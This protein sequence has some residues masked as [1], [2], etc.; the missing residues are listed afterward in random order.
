[1]ITFFDTPHRAFAPLNVWRELDRVMRDFDR[2]QPPSRR[3]FSQAPSLTEHQDRYELVMAAP[4]VTPKDVEIQ[5]HE[6]VLSLRAEAKPAPQEGY[7]AT[8]RERGRYD[9][10]HSYRLPSQ[11]DASS[12]QASLVDGVLTIRVAKVPKPEPKLIPVSGA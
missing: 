4:G 1:M 6:G 8:H 5:V 12:V 10:S 7:R 11:A 9:Y 2:A 3:S